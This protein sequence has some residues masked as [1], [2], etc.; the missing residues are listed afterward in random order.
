LPNGKQGPR[1]KET[2]AFPHIDLSST[3]NGIWLCTTCHPKIDND[4]TWYPAQMLF[5][6]KKG[7]EAIIRRLPGLDLEAALL[8]LR[9]HKR[10]HQETR[11]L[12]SFLDD[13]R[14]LYEGMD[15][16]F[17]PRVL[18][19][20]ALMRA[21]IIQTRALVSADSKVAVALEGMQTAINTFLKKVGPRVDLREL[22]C[23]SADPVW[24]R[25][26][27]QVEDFRAAMRITIAYLAEGSGYTVKHIY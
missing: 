27:G 19:S 9:Q 12:L 20:I 13:R 14:A 18:E 16:E 6:W 4:P 23:N 5:D 21:R 15:Y 22:V 3:A 8:E 10:Y 26:K 17:P 2:T 1:S 24:V 11:E 25:F 7:H